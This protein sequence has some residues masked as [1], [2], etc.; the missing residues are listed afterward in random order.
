MP[1]IEPGPLAAIGLTKTCTVLRGTRGRLCRITGCVLLA[2]LCLLASMGA[3][4]Q[5]VDGRTLQILNTAIQLLLGPESGS[6][7]PRIRLDGSLDGL[8]VGQDL[9]VGRTVRLA[10]APQ[11]PVDV[12]LRVDA[13][14]TA[15]LSRD[16]ASAGTGEVTFRGVTGEVVGE[17]YVQGQAAGNTVLRVEAT[18]YAEQSVSV[19]VVPSGLVVDTAPFVTNLGAGLSTV[20]WRTAAL[21]PSS[22]ALLDYQPLRGG[23]SVAFAAQSSDAAVGSVTDATRTTYS[24][25]NL[26]RIEPNT[27][28]VSGGFWPLTSGTTSLRAAQPPGFTGSSDRDAVTV[29][30][31]SVPAGRRARFVFDCDLNGGIGVLIMDVEVVQDTGIVW[32]PGADPDISGV[33]ATG[34]YDLF[35]EGLLSSFHDGSDIRYGFT[36]RNQFAD[37]FRIGLPERFRV[38]WVEDGDELVMVINPFG[39]GP[40]Q[41]RCTPTGSSYL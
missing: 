31:D 20:V 1:R 29:T 13:S 41:H 12:T 32:G 39:P 14:A 8:T 25:D 4:A 17:V 38:Q 37:F 27:D 30:V 11:T 33:I 34:S 16:P 35:T 36:G 5:T 26:L 3:A 9:Q 24:I 2:C 18:G 6:P 40:T 15:T 10:P 22:F 23:Q 21:D 19:R 7:G 28:S